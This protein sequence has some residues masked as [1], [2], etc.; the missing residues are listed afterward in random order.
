[1]IDAFETSPS[2][3]ALDEAMAKAQASIQ[4]AAKDKVNPHFRSK[5]ADLASVWEACR[6]ALTSNGVFVSQWPVHS[7]DGRLHMITRLAHKGEWIKAR[8]SIPVS[9]QDAQGYAASLTYCKR[10]GLSAAVGVVADD[11]DDGESAV[12]RSRQQAAPARMQEAPKAVESIGDTYV[13]K[14]NEATT[15]EAFEEE[16][17]KARA[18]W[19]RFN[20]GDKTKVANSIEARRAF[21]AQSP[22]V[23]AAE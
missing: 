8:F 7:E 21:W 18:A 6:D 12:G 23:E 20:A 17:A 15:A 3:A 22:A 11:D 13:R 9:K 10:M 14:F 5:Y 1:M 19:S 16:V 2:T 4:A